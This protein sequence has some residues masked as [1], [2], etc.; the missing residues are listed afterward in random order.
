[1]ARPTTQKA[2]EAD[3][4]T[5]DIQPLLHPI[6]TILGAIIIAAAI[7]IA[8]VPTTSGSVAGD[9]LATSS[10]AA[11]LPEEPVTASTSVDDDA[12]LGNKSTA[13]VAIIEFSDYECPYCQR[14]WAETLGQ[15][16]TNYI[17]TGKVILVF[18]D[19]PLS[20]HPNAEIYAN[21][22]E[23]ARSQGGDSKYYAMH[24]AIFEKTADG[25][26]SVSDLGNLAAELGLDKSKLEA[27]VNNRDFAAEIQAD[28]DHA[29]AIGINGTP[30]FVIGKLNSDG[31]LTGDIIS[32]A[33]PYANFEETIEKFLQSI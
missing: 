28:A 7:I 13:T 23:C 22:T 15:I 11:I 32:G 31:T 4:I 17:D 30:G 29:A 26:L 27:C 20:F 21:A 12:V 3:V 5:I 24:D 18:R 10:A 19:L 8:K 14:F 9:S 16:K 6:A 2:A 33:M 1:M 25:E